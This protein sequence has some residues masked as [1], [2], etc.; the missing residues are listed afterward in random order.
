MRK[1]SG[2]TLKSPRQQR[3]G[4]FA[5]SFR[6]LAAHPHHIGPSWRRK[7]SSPTIPRPLCKA[8]YT[9]RD[10]LLLNNLPRY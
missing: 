6:E 10:S 2:A 8:S 5:A 3:R 9:L 1:G 4:V 7:H